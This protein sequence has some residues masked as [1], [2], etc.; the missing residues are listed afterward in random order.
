METSTVSVKVGKYTFNIIESLAGRD[1][2][3]LIHSF[4]IGGR[5][6]NCIGVSYKYIGLKPISAKISFVQYEPECSFDVDLEKNGGTAIMLKTLLK[7]VYKKIPSV[8]L[9]TL[10]DMS[11]IDCAEKDLTQPPPRKSKE[12]LNLAY[13]SIAYN[14]STWYE[15][16]F[17]AVMSDTELYNRYR[18]KLD[19]LTNPSKKPEYNG[20]VQIACIPLEQ[21]DY[22][23]TKYE[24]A[25]TYREFFKAI[26]FEDKCEI[27]SPWLNTF[28]EHYITSVYKTNDWV[29]DVRSPKFNSIKGSGRR[30]TVKNSTREYGSKYRIVMFKNIHN[31]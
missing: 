23:R 26:P 10:D 1:D 6:N 30:K 16:Y 29:I 2:M 18:D 20:F 8:N 31:I 9:F 7:Y 3:I 13:L 21:Y 14:S 5:Y 19:F 27:L 24:E 17:G 4:K 22:L 11:H 15:K 28:I 25:K 12:P